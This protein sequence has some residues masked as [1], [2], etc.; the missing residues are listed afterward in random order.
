ML[1]GTCWK[2]LNFSVWG[3]FRKWS[4]NGVIIGLPELISVELCSIVKAE[5]VGSG[6]GPNFGR[7][8]AKN[9]PKLKS[10]FWFSNAN[11][12]QIGWLPE[13]LITYLCFL[14]RSVTKTQSAHEWD[15]QLV[16]GAD[17]WCNLH[18]FSSRGLARGSRG[19]PWAPRG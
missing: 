7:T 2:I 13:T 12:N 6:P 11:P 15:L 18:H 1:G 19:P 3:S 4:Q 16:S 14:L 8:P 17:F 10:R 5:A 9:L